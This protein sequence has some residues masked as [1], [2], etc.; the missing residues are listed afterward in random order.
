MNEPAVLVS[1][2]FGGLL[3]VV[4]NE[5]NCTC[6]I[7]LWL[8]D[9]EGACHCSVQP[10]SCGSDSEVDDITAPAAAAAGD[11]SS[12]D[13]NTCSEQQQQQQQQQQ[14]QF[15]EKEHE[16]EDEAEAQAAAEAAAQRHTSQQW[17]LGA[18]LTVDSCLYAEVSSGPVLVVEILVL[19]AMLVRTAAGLNV[20]RQFL[21][22]LQLC[23]ARLYLAFAVAQHICCVGT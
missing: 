8:Q 16:R 14:E 4:N 17:Q 11:T 19:L 6:T 2:L 23:S 18:T 22:V 21:D 9:M 1:H 10:L 20:K 5:H 13:A 12:A 7:A 3:A 15:D